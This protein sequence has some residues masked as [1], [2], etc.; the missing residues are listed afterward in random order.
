MVTAHKERTDNQ[1]SEHDDIDPNLNKNDQ[2]INNDSNTNGSCLNS[3]D[4]E[5]NHERGNLATGRLTRNRLNKADSNLS[6][7]KRGLVH[8]TTNDVIANKRRRL[9]KKALSQPLDSSQMTMSDLI[10]Y[11]PST[12]PMKH[13]SDDSIVDSAFSN[14]NADTS[15]NNDTIDS[16]P[17]GKTDRLPDREN[18][19]PQVSIGP[20]GKI[21]LNEESL[22]IE[23]SS[24]PYELTDVIDES[25]SLT[26]YRSY[27]KKSTTDRW[28]TGG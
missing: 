9:K 1:L 7:K 23:A 25:D 14:G 5:N 21:I 20:D 3:N 4:N 26:T 15:E 27:K 11:N 22:V 24:V 2:L 17:Q 19:A 8:H 6:K 28:S 18:R 16:E 13:K 10:Y 12:N